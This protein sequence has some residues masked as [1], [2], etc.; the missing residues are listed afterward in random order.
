M[1]GKKKAATKKATVKKTAKK[2]AKTTKKTVRKKAAA[3]KA[4]KT[5]TP[6]ERW[7]M[8]SDA[9]YYRAEQ[10]GFTGGDPAKDWSDAEAEIDAQLGSE[11]GFSKLMA[12][13]DPSKIMEKFSK[14]ISEYDFAGVDLKALLESQRKNVEA[15]SAA[16]KQALQ[17]VR[18]VVT[19]QSEILRHA[20]DEVSVAVKDLSK[21]GG[22][23]DLAA[24]E[25]EL[26]KQALEKALA[27]MRELTETIAKSNTAAFA[28]V[29]E[30]V[31]QSV[32]ELKQ[33]VARLKR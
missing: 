31:T 21:A 19:R 4:G 5:V 7:K 1:A 33:L 24:K 9:A 17:G 18:D 30:R 15:L 23:K 12:D 27:N 10:R 2:A 11:S 22:P 28:T 16:N 20:M 26:V 3:P 14:T 13:L 8:I 25:A 6:E 32:Q 29:R